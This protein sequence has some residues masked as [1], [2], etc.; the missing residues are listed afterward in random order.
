MLWSGLAYPA[1]G[2]HARAE[3]FKFARRVLNP[4]KSCAGYCQAPRPHGSTAASVAN[5]DH[6]DQ[7]VRRTK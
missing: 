1:E 7:W 5:R 4:P 2:G 6:L 3:L